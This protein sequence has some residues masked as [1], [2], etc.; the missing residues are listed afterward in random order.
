MAM[1]V[2]SAC[3]GGSMGRALLPQSASPATQNAAVMPPDALLGPGNGDVPFVGD[4]PVR[5]L[6][7]T[8]SFDRAQC[9]AMMRTD[10]KPELRMAPQIGGDAETCPF[11]GIAYCP[12]DLQDAYKLPSLSE[13]KEKVVAIVDAYGYHHAAGDLAEYRKTMGLKAC[14]TSTKCFRI[15]NQEGNPSPLPQEPPANDD[16][17]GEQS[18]DLDMVSAICPNCKIILV[19][20]NDDYTSNLYAGVKTAGRIGAKYISNSWGGGES[21]G[22]NSIFHQT[23]VVITA[24]AGDEGGGGHYGGGPAQPCSYTYVVCVGGT[25]LVRAQN[26]RG[27]SESVWNDWNFDQCGSSGGQPCGATGSGCSTKIAKPSWQTDQ[28]CRMRSEADVAATASL[29][30]P[31]AV[32]NSE[33]GGNCPSQC[34]FAFG[35]TSASTPII[36][37][38]FALAGNAGTQNGASGIWKRHTGN[39][40]DV[41]TGNNLDPGRGVNCASTV[42]YICTAR[43]GFDGPAGWGT[44]KGIG[45]F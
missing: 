13:G 33:E 39:L 44:P 18:L 36:A 24:A 20:T 30:A 34:F 29:R 15:V 43:F 10:M 16:W 2:L 38:V 42:K 4:N 3:S 21:G 17:K 14:A 22:D 5:K 40:F 8:P 12:N 6:C 45:A 35:G 11:E 23:G 41:T 26:Q 9:F 27:W 37:A 19:Q 32:Y 7:S 31:V 28:G 1:L 25:H